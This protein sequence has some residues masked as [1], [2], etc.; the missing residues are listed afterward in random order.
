MKSTNQNENFPK[1]SMFSTF[2]TLQV[3]SSQKFVGLSDGNRSGG[4][5]HNRTQILV[6]KSGI[7]GIL[8]AHPRTDQGVLNF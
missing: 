3:N 8:K 2:S 7:K 4:L 6:S 1:K 5:I